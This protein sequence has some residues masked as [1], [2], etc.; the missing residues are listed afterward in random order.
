MKAGSHSS[1]P[2][3]ITVRNR[4][5]SLLYFE[6]KSSRYLGLLNSSDSKLWGIVFS[7]Q[8]IWQ[9]NLGIVCLEIGI[10]PAITGCYCCCNFGINGRGIKI[11]LPFLPLWSWIVKIST[12][13]KSHHPLY[14]LNGQVFGFT[15]HRRVRC[16]YLFI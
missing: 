15:I 5:I 3:G 4:T 1:E 6:S 16:A 8:L 9:K 10:R 7:I 14:T 2:I 12:L 13:K 11:V